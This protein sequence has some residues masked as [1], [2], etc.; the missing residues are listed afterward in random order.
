[1]LHHSI[2]TW[3]CITHSFSSSSHLPKDV[4][5]EALDRMDAMHQCE[6][7]RKTSINMMVGLWAT[8]S[9]ESW[10]V[11]SSSSIEDSFNAESVRH[12][13]WSGG[14]IH[15]FYTRSVRQTNGSMRPIHDQIM[16]IE[17]TRVATLRF[18][19]ESL[20]TPRRCITDVKTDALVLHGFSNSLHHKLNHICG[21]TVRQLSGVK[22][23]AYHLEDDQTMLNSHCEIT[24]SDVDANVYRWGSEPKRLDGAYAEPYRDCKPPAALGA[25]TDLSP[26]TARDHVLQ[27]GS[28]LVTGAPGTG[29]TFWARELVADL[30][31]SGLRVDIIAKTHLSVQN[32]GDGAVTADHWVRKYIRRGCC[33]CQVLVCEEMSQL[34]CYLWNDIAKCQLA[35]CR[36]ILLGDFKQF[37]AICDTWC[38]HPVPE[39]ALQSSDLLYEL[40]GGHRMELTVNMRSDAVLFDMYT[41]LWRDGVV[42]EDALRVARG[43]FPLKENP[44][45][46][47]LCISHA[48]RKAVNRTANLRERCQHEATFLKGPESFWTWPG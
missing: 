36:S 5:R 18:I 22:R 41:G 9:Q 33:P 23:K 44:A 30:R 2:I 20:G 47:T 39:G 14:V 26:E 48:E 13:Q 16:S 27:G 45:R 29:K 37:S 8:H 34:S 35:G 7:S 46:F 38:G 28:L 40:S 21:T 1:M 19:L 24:G 42:F 25:W 15:D 11:K 3:E 12:F 43:L 6:K 4:F 32:F 31:K 10:T 17:H